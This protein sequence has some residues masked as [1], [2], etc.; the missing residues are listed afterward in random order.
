M[1]AVTATEVVAV[2]ADDTF[3]V[4][5]RNRPLIAYDEGLV[6]PRRPMG[7]PGAE[8][9]GAPVD[10]VIEVVDGQ[11]RVLM[12]KHVA[13]RTVAWTRKLLGWLEQFPGVDWEARW[14]AC[15]ADAAPRTWADV[16]AA[17]G[18]EAAVNR[19]GFVGGS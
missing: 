12:A 18:S 2:A 4:L 13:N 3:D 17:A 16:P 5:R 19:P 11:C 8:L 6:A 14:L 10:D 9:V 1:T 15:G 7:G